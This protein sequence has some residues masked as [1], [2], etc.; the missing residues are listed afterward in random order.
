MERNYVSEKGKI[1][2]EINE[3]ISSKI[4][5][6]TMIIMNTEYF[7]CCSQKDIEDVEHLLEVRVFDEKG[8]KKE[9]KI[10]RPTI[11]DEFFYRLIDE[12]NCEYEHIDELQYLDI[13]ITKSSGY[14]YVATGGGK[15]TLP[16]E[17]ADRVKIRNYISY[18]EQG[19][20][21]IT[22]FRVV[23]IIKKGCEG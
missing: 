10:F 22:D 11:A 18:D 2:G 19:I 4:S 5:D 16:I 20:A 13:D 15:Y 8:E 21:Q 14:D 1:Q 12:T 7:Q 17:N 23:K 6:G 9:L 3:F